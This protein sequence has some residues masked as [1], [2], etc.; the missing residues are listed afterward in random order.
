M[1]K[2]AKL[3]TIAVT[4]RWPVVLFIEGD[5]SRPTD[6]RPVPPIVNY[7]RARWDVLEGLTEM[8]GW[9]PTVAVA[10]GATCDSHAAMAFLCD[11]VIATRDAEFGS[12]IDSSDAQP[13]DIAAARGDVDVLVD[14]IHEAITTTRQ[15]LSYWHDDISDFSASD[16]ASTISQIVPD[17]RRRAYD[18][19]KVITAFADQGSVFEVGAAWAESLITAFARVEGRAVGIFANQPLSPRAG[20]IDSAA[21]DKA[22]RFVEWCDA[23][24]LPLISFVDNPGYMVGPDAE[25]EGIARHHARPLS[26]IHHRTVPLYTVQL[27]KAYGLGPFAM[28]G[29]GASRKMPELRVAWPTVESGGMSLEGAAYLVKRKEIRDAVDAVTARTI[30][31]QYAEEM[32]DVASGVRA[33]RTFSFDDVILPEETRPLIASMLKRSHRVLPSTK[34]HHIDT[35]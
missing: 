11:I 34:I 10:V 4:N 8:S 31:D 18:M 24:A 5:G 20:A 33:G 12:N 9:A 2:L 35:R 15:F 29:Y 21:A 1:R 7:T 23:Y 16:S 6:P 14:D 19:R 22:C 3:I 28:S 30:R 17:N 32:R 13:S 25:R 26:A 27:R